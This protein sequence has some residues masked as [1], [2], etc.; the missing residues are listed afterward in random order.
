MNYKYV[1]PGIRE[2]KGFRH[3]IYCDLL[4]STY[5]EK[6]ARWCVENF[7]NHG[8]KWKVFFYWSCDVSQLSGWWSGKHYYKMLF[9]FKNK[10]DALLFK[11]TWS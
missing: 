4:Y 2:T 11:M 7:G 5:D 8:D 6:V 3:H 9:I 10:E 1:C